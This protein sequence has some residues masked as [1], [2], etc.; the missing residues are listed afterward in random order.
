MEQEGR[1]ELL[2]AVLLSLQGDMGFPGV[3]LLAME[4]LP[5]LIAGGGAGQAAATALAKLAEL[6]EAPAVDVSRRGTTI[7]LVRLLAL[8][9]IR[10]LAATP[11]LRAALSSEATAGLEQ[12]ATNADPAVRTAALLA[13]GAVRSTS[14]SA[15]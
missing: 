12:R 2:D 4:T 13:L 9:A 6:L 15:I 8:E 5:E 14:A 11:S 7:H 1:A 3:G 10:R